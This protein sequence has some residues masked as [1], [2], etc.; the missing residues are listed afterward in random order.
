MVDVFGRWIAEESYESYPKEKWCDCDY[1]AYWIKNTGY[2]PK[3]SIENLVNMTLTYY[4][5]YLY[6]NDVEFYTDI[7]ESEN[8]NMISIEDVCCFVEDNGGLREFDYYC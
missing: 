8:G 6:D 7:K 4:D 2:T 5:G 3:T 1:I